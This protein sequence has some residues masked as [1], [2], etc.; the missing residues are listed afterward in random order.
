MTAAQIIRLARPAL[1]APALI[2]KRTPLYYR[3]RWNGPDNYH[4]RLLVEG[5]AG[6]REWVDVQALL[7]GGWDGQ[8]VTTDM[9]SH[10]IGMW[11][12]SGLVIPGSQT[13]TASGS[14]VVSRYNRLEVAPWGAGG[15]GGTKGANDDATAGGASTYASST[16]VVGNGGGRARSS[17]AGGAGGA[18]GTA[19]GGDS[20]VT[21]EAGDNGSPSNA[22]DGASG[23]GTLLG[24]LTG[25]VGSTGGSN[26][27]PDGLP[28]GGGGG[29]E[30]GG[31][32]T[33][34]GGGGGGGLAVKLWT[35]GTAGAPLTG[36]TITVTIGTG[37]TGGTGN[38]GAADGG[39]GEGRAAW[40]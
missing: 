32:G 29:G 20:N 4:G 19:T 39:R 12:A 14:H 17:G 9:L 38:G 21:G 15:G 37:G 10:V 30:N 1:A 2:V 7:D 26:T 35:P 23:T 5:R 40:D 11:G 16:P 3:G 24:T 6:A 34:G 27:R 36:E 22:G 31:T 18:G 13:W 28:P 33:K 25:G 8:P